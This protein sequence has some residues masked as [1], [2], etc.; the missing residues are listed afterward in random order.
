MKLI[1]DI[2]M[3]LLLFS[4]PFLICIPSIGR[5]D[6]N[7]LGYLKG[8]ET[9]PKGSW[10]VYQIM[11][12]RKD[13]GFGKY[14]ALDSKT[15][16][17]YGVSDRFSMSTSLSFLSIDT[18]DIRID[19]YVPADEN[20][21]FKPMGVE[22]GFKYNFL[23]AAKDDLGLS[24]YLSFENNWLD[25]HSGQKKDTYTMDLL[26]ILQKYFLEGELIWNSNIGFESTYAKRYEVD[27]LPA[28]FEWPTEPEVEIETSLGTGIS[29]RFAPNWFAGAETIYETEYET[30]VG[31]ERW[32]HFAGPSLHYGSQT[33]W[34]TLTWFKQ[35][36]GGGEKFD[37]Q[38]DRKLHLIE[39][40]K[41][42]LRLKL[43]FNF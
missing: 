18:S 27:D 23:S 16:L 15:E 36:S 41:Q 1:K 9:L 39:K 26:F 13:K 17:E 19:A 35:F 5:A 20:Y 43:G 33:W 34:A 4:M 10:E 6:E 24:S 11:T 7:L 25:K 40:T 37:D 29:Y 38:D 42:E 14:E 22:V 32:S 31:L 3:A 28:G 2:N 30:E 12:S 8:A 21:S